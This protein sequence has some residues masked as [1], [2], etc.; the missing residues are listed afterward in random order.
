MTPGNFWMRWVRTEQKALWSVSRFWH[1]VFFTQ[2]TVRSALVSNVNIELYNALH[3]HMTKQRL[4]TK[5]LKN[6][7][8]VTSMYNDLGLLINH[9]ANGVSI[10]CCCHSPPC[11]WTLV[12]VVA[13]KCLLC[14]GGDSELRQD[15]LRQPDCHQRSGACHRSCHHRC[16]KHHPKRPWCWRWLDNSECEYK[17]G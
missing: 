3:Y 11:S 1:L 8:T 17:R 9:Y 5:D 4:L 2:Q 15:Y 12:G 16:W 14:S 6:G 10:Q 7:M 13:L